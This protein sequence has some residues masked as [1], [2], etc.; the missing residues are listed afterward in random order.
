SAQ[1]IQVYPMQNAPPAQA[2]GAFSAKRGSEH[3]GDLVERQL[4]RSLALEQGD[5]HGEL[6]ALRLDLTDR[7]GQARERAFLD[8]DGLADLEVDLRGDGAGDSHASLGLN[9]L[10]GRNVL[11]L[12]E[13]L[14]HVE[15]LF[16]AQR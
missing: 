10:R 9:V 12:D 7:T 16:E 2:D 8:R 14:Q 4:D 1:T 5:E 6:A 11:D 15:G 3:L 13:R